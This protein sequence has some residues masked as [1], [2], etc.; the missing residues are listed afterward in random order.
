VRQLVIKVLDSSC[1]F[2]CPLKTTRL[3]VDEFSWTFI[4]GIITKN[5]SA[6]FKCG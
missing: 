6:K 1:L 2:V 4:L 3:P 5:L